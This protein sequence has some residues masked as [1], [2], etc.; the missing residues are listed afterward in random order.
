MTRI[1]RP[2]A[3]CATSGLTSLI[4][5]NPEDELEPRA[6]RARAGLRRRQPRLHRQGGVLEHAA[7][8]LDL[9]GLGQGAPDDLDDRHLGPLGGVG[10]AV[11]LAVRAAGHRPAPFTPC[12]AAGAV[13]AV[14]RAAAA[15]PQRRP[16]R[17]G[18]AAL[19]DGHRPVR[20]PARRLRDQR[21]AWE[22]GRGGQRASEISSPAKNARLTRARLPRPAG[23][24]DRLRR[25][26]DLRPLPPVGRRTGPLGLRLDGSSG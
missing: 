26:V 7:Q 8:G 6:A 19:P 11:L 12:G 25:P 3:G 4:E 13:V 10:R 1:R 22:R 15:L 16:A 9:A 20:D 23:G 5:T 18:D 24:G 21:G 14:D 2:G 17:R